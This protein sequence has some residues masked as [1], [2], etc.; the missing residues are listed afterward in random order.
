MRCTAAAPRRSLRGAGARVDQFRRGRLRR[1]GSRRGACTAPDA[2]RR[3]GSGHSPGCRGPR[4][5]RRCPWRAGASRSWPRTR[6]SPRRCRCSTRSLARGGPGRPR[7]R[8]DR[9]AQGQWLRRWPPTGLRR[10]GLRRRNVIERC[11]A[12]LEQ[13]RAL[14]TRY[15]WPGRRSRADSTCIRALNINPPAPLLAWMQPG[16]AVA[17]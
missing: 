5:G 7:K 12:R 1:R 11:F 3:A 9:P 17:A 13:F 6:W 2:S 15:G 4:C 8:P 10:R 16:L 14:A